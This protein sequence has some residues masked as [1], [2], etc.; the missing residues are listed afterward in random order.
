MA[1]N[2]YV[3]DP[4]TGAYRFSYGDSGQE[5]TVPDGARAYLEA[6]R[7]EREN[8][9]LAQGEG[10][11]PGYEIPGAVSGDQGSGTRAPVAPPSML[12]AGSGGA[13]GDGGGGRGQGARAVSTPPELNYSPAP[14]T[15]P[16]Q[17]TQPLEPAGA[18][19]APG[20]QPGAYPVE[21]GQEGGGAAGGAG[22]VPA[23]VPPP[24]ADGGGGAQGAPGAPPPPSP[25]AGAA[26]PGGAQAGVQGAPPK[27]APFAGPAKPAPGRG[28][29]GGGGAPAGPRE[30][31]V[32]RSLQIE[33]R[34]SPERQAEMEGVIQREADLGKRAQA[35]GE[36]RLAL[37][38][39]AEEGQEKLGKYHD[40][41][42]RE[43]QAERQRA[44][45]EL[46]ARRDA[47]LK[48]IEESKIDP[49]RLWQG[50]AGTRNAI[51]AALAAGLGAVGA[52]IGGGPNL[53]LQMVEKAIDRDLDLQE[54]EIGKKRADLSEIGRVYQQEKERFGDKIIARNE[55]K[56][57]ALTAAKA[58]AER[59]AKLSNAEDAGIN[60]AKI[61]LEADKKIAALRAEN[62]GRIKETKSFKTIMPSSGG[63]PAKKPQN[64][65]TL[66][67][68]DGKGGFLDKFVPFPKGMSEGL[69]NDMVKRAQGLNRAQ[70]TLADL[71]G[72][73]G[74]GIP[75][76]DEDVQAYAQSFTYDYAE[77]FGQGQATADQEKSVA[78]K[79]RTSLNG[80]SRAI[81]AYRRSIDQAQEEIYR[82]LTPPAEE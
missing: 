80:G 33:G 1:R 46:S 58:Q 48:E 37:Q 72:K 13:P 42:I 78:N 75:I 71:E 64:G 15:G 16:N 62:D 54:K 4:A 44:L 47:K 23:Y 20:S 76:N 79:L 31:M 57:A 43:L 55:A 50:K 73:R 67:V 17:S 10:G 65:V 63:A 40:D 56:I 32:G 25:D 77:G 69:K 2:S 81:G 52:A 36:E 11:R 5:I 22:P 29:G 6:R 28:G 82:Q 39:R 12:D 14:P 18:G 9:M 53:G 24:P 8:A 3:Q 41:Q 30:M 21:P 68:S 34:L 51:A 60:I 35:R 45:D 26:A 49:A 38:T 66:R 59:Y 70:A 61:Q 74:A 7:I 19:G 27:L